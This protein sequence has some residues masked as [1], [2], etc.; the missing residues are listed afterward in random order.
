MSQVTEMQKNY[1]KKE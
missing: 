1:K